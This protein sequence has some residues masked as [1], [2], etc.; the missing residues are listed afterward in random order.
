MHIFTFTDPQVDAPFQAL[1]R[2]GFRC[3]LS[4]DYDLDSVIRS[5][6]LMKEM[7]ASDRKV[8]MVGCIHILPKSLVRGLNSKVCETA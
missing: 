6:E 1:A 5:P 8:A 3:M 4:G 2:S 7:E